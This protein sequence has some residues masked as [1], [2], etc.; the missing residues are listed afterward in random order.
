MFRLCAML[1]GVGSPAQASR[2]RD[3]QPRRLDCSGSRRRRQRRRRCRRRTKTT[4]PDSLPH[5]SCSSR[6][7]PSTA[8]LLESARLPSLRGM[9]PRELQRRQRHEGFLSTAA[10]GSG[11]ARPADTLRLQQL[12]SELLD[13]FQRS[14]CLRNPAAAGHE[15]RRVC[16]FVCPSS[17][18]LSLCAGG[19]RI[20]QELLASLHPAAVTGD[21]RLLS[22]NQPHAPLPP[23]TIAGRMSMPPLEG[24]DSR[25]CRQ[26]VTPAA[27][28][29]PTRVLGPLRAEGARWHVGAA[30]CRAPVGRASASWRVCLTQ[31]AYRYQGCLQIDG[32]AERCPSA[33]PWQR[34]TMHQLGKPNLPLPTLQVSTQWIR[35]M[36]RRLGD[37]GGGRQRAH[38]GPPALSCRG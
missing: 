32:A 22:G 6:L 25:P 5:P 15:A 23:W 37:S 33:P 3:L 20:V 11:A 28:P 24:K 19:L 13:E 34:C 38:S 21:A 35:W 7:C 18:L 16:Q 2:Q 30:C 12:P 4:A 10:A 1:D 26:Q 29:M 27:M 31:A 17:P 14:A 8:A 36:D 9:R